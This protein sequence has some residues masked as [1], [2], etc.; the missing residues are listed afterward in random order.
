M[1]S[2]F[3]D[4]HQNFSSFSSSLFD[5]EYVHKRE[6]SRL[7][8]VTKAKSGENRNSGRFHSEL[9]NKSCKIEEHTSSYDNEVESFWTVKKTLQLFLSFMNFNHSKLYK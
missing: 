9:I 6:V 7:F 5:L 2:L 4:N 1:L 8:T 3:Q